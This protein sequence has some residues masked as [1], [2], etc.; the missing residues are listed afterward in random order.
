MEQEQAIGE[1][2]ECA[3][4]EYAFRQ[5]F[6]KSDLKQVLPRIGEAPFD[7]QRKMMST[8]HQT[9]NQFVQLPKGRL[10]RF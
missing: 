2:T 7:S 4:V 1:P 9:A 10:M 5:G 3:L 8:V 6:N